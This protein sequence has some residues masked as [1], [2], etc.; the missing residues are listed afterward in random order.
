MPFL[1]RFV[2]DGTV[3]AAAFRAFHAPHTFESE[4]CRI[5]ETTRHAIDHYAAPDPGLLRERFLLAQ[6]VLHGVHRVAS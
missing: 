4:V 2:Q 3:A 1:A 6:K 5:H